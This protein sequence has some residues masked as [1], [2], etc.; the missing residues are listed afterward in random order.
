MNIIFGLV[1]QLRKSIR[2]TAYKWYEDERANIGIQQRLKQCEVQIDNT[3][4]RR[5]N[6]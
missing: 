2:F 3:N 6:E 1:L 4:V 5:R